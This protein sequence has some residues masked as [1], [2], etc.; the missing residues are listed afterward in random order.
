[1]LCSRLQP[2]CFGNRW[3]PA[4]SVVAA[5]GRLFW[6]YPSVFKAVRSNTSSFPYNWIGRL[7]A[8]LKTTYI[9]VDIMT[10]AAEQRSTCWTFVVQSQT[11]RQGLGKHHGLGLNMMLLLYLRNLYVMYV[12]LFHYV[13]KSNKFTIEFWLHSVHEP[14]NLSPSLLLLFVLNLLT[15]SSSAASDLTKGRWL[16]TNILS[17]WVVIN[18]LQQFPSCSHFLMMKNNA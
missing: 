16:K 1:M 15:S 12:A 17:I 11:T 7:S 5:L 4:R 6:F 9:T 10:S 8:P 14:V 3:R 13:N 18:I 2:C